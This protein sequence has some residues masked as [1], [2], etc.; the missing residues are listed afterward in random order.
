LRKNL[1]TKEKHR[2]LVVM[3]IGLEVNTDKASI[4]YCFI[5]RM[6]GQNL[7]IKIGNKSVWYVVVF[8]YLGDD[9]KKLRAS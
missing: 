8:K 6:P 1:D 5:S 3:D 2:S 7:N 4:C 9:M